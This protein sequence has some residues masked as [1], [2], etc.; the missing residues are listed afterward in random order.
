ML[1]LSINSAVE[2]KSGGSMPLLGFGL[3]QSSASHASTSVALKEGY[4]H[5]DSA[6][7]YEN[8]AEM[9]TAIAEWRQSGGKGDVF[10]TSKVYGPDH[11]TEKCAAAVEESVANAK[12]G[13]LKW[14]LYLLHDPTAGPEKRVEAWRV[15]ER[16]VSEGK[17]LAIGVS[18]FSDV[19]LEELKA[20]GVKLTPEVNQIELHP[21]C[22]QKKIV[23][24]CR[25]KGIIVQAYCPLVRGLR[26]NDP[27]LQSICQKTGKTEAQVLIRW[28]LQKGFVPLPKSDT[29][30]RI[31]ENADVFN[32]EL[33]ED[34]MQKL[35]ALDLGKEGACQW[36][37]V[38]SP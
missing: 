10:V 6:R 30:S 13:G 12:V 29:P 23:E 9:A 4:R 17:L 36:N 27:V 35:D 32:F 22:Q 14:D 11:A 18:N 34:S 24:Y 1:K 20:S 33:D 7:Y 31:R 21:W 38:D 15:L 25:A 2:L 5:I 26:M 16:A 19:H 3:Y 37:P 28:S 8:E